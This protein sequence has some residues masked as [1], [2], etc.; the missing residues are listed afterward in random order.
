NASAIVPFCETIDDVD[1][2]LTLQGLRLIHERN[3]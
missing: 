1:E 2:L 3:R